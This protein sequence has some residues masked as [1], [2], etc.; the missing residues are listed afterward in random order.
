MRLLIDI[1]LLLFLNLKYILQKYNRLLFI[2]NLKDKIQ[3]FMLCLKDKIQEF[4]LCLKGKIHR[5]NF[6]YFEISRGCQELRLKCIKIE[7]K[8]IFMGY[9]LYT[10][11]YTLD[12]MDLSFKI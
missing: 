5:K 12:I 9:F 3:E 8:R 2:M 4:M 1:H 10:S 6:G 11:E 7:C